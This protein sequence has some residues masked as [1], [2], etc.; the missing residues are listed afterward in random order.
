M[1]VGVRRL[2]S[3]TCFGSTVSAADVALDQVYIAGSGGV[4]YGDLAHV[5]GW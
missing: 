4:E 2:R 1:R 3:G 5:A